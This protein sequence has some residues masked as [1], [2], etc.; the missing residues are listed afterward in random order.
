MP[1]QLRNLPAGSIRGEH[2]RRGSDHQPTHPAA[3]DEVERFGDHDVPV[4]APPGTVIIQLI[5][6]GRT[7]WAGGAV[8]V[9]AVITWTR[10]ALRAAG[11]SGVSLPVPWWTSTPVRAGSPAS[12]RRLQRGFPQGMNH[13]RLVP[14][15][16]VPGLTLTVEGFTAK[17]RRMPGAVGDRAASRGLVLAW[18][19]AAVLPSAGGHGPLLRRVVPA[20]VAQRDGR[21]GSVGRPLPG[22][23]ASTRAHPRVS[24][25]HVRLLNNPLQSIGPRE[26]IP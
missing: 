23:S 5:C 7:P 4:P 10:S 3:P 2:A 20:A 17:S 24:S 21:P 14:V 22:S 19:L 13:L 11:T 26:H 15:L 1:G 12:D 16:A 6:G 18:P 8:Y 25:R 9:G